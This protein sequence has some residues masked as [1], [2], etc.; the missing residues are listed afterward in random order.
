MV[1][2]MDRHQHGLTMGKRT[3]HQLSA[4]A[5]QRQNE[6]G[7]YL[8]GGGLYLRVRDGRRKTWVFRY[9]RRDMGL[10]AY[11]A[12]PLV[13]AR[14]LAA[15]AREQ[16]AAGIDP[17]EARR[18]SGAEANKNDTAVKQVMTFDLAVEEF[19]E[20]RE[21]GWRNPKHRQQWRNT[22]KT[23]ASPVIGKKDIADI[24][25]Q[26]VVNI[27]KPIWATK[28]ETA[29]RLRGRIENVLDWA[30]VQGH[31]SGENPAL[32]RGHLSHLLP[33]QNKKLTV[34]HHA[35]MPWAEV[36]A[37]MVELRAN[38]AISSKALQFTT[39]T[40]VRTSEAIEATW[41]EIDLDARLWI[42]PKERMKAGVEF[43]VPLT[44]AAITLLKDL[45]RVD[46]T[47]YLFPG[48]RKGRP[49]SNMAMLEL[50]RG[51]RPG[52]TVHGFRSSFRD[53]AGDSTGFPRD[54][55]EMC[56]AHSVDNDVE[57]AYRR[58][59]MIEKRRKVMEG[60]AKFCGSGAKKPAGKMVA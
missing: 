59:D 7:L 40:A 60:W 29:S 16:L 54:T 5:V 57:A 38:A 34:E 31:R 10:G 52:L 53:W 41:N 17:L 20:G 23:Y 14:H 50:L 32:W 43:R 2:N 24:T 48:A 22:L 19:L 49:L 44:D 56:L 26:D 28:A 30:R 45:P 13:A 12:V 35:A 9:K 51:M 58:S 25:T 4:L 55:V 36:P 15:A 8:D 6:P 42:I 37:F 21:G 47:P 33:A 39:L 46:G 3:L 11:P 18:A 27:L 1:Q